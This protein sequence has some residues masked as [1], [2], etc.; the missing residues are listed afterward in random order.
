MSTRTLDVIFVSA[1]LLG[2][3]G[4]FYYYIRGVLNRDR[5]LARSAAIAFVVLSVAAVFYWW[6]VV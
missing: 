4:C 2:A 6:R 3:L 5:L 1:A